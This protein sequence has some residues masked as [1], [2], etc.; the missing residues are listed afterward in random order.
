[1][2]QTM[3]APHCFR[4]LL[5][6]PFHFSFYLQR[7]R[8][9]R[10]WSH[11]RTTNQRPTRMVQSI[12]L[13]ARWK[14]AKHTRARPPPRPNNNLPDK[15]IM[16]SLTISADSKCCSECSCEIAPYSWLGR[17]LIRFNS[18]L[19]VEIY[20]SGLGGITRTTT[21]ER[22]KCKKKL[23][24]GRTCWVFL[25]RRGEERQV[26]RQ[27]LMLCIPK[28]L[29]LLVVDNGNK[30]CIVSQQGWCPVTDLCKVRYPL[31]QSL[32][33][34]SRNRTIYISIHLYMY[35][36]ATYENKQTIYVCKAVWIVV[37]CSCRCFVDYML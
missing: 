7:H 17:R 35:H 12:H 1:M 6:C 25:K 24:G 16:V 36:I 10:S 11:P 8:T 28:A 9:Q 19:I 21:G 20:I 3:L 33:L 23:L 15:P 5:S 4:M 2:I 14:S 37:Q 18:A 13:W 22:K 29:L 27:D 26:Q 34:A 30:S 31:Q 32:D